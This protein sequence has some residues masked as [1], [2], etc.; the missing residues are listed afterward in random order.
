[1][2]GAA[3]NGIQKVK[4]QYYHVKIL[5]LN[6][7]FVVEEC[8]KYPSRFSIL[9]FDERAAYIYLRLVRARIQVF[10]RIWI[11]GLGYRICIP[12]IILKPNRC[13]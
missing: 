12:I 6:D 10:G 5:L 4:D 3:G 11:Q 7:A 9:G 1:M 2:P 8:V 13:L